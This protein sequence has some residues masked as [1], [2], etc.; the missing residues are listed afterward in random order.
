MNKIL[1]VV[2]QPPFLLFPASGSGDRAP[3]ISVHLLAFYF[4]ACLSKA[5][6][7]KLKIE[8]F[9]D[10]AAGWVS[11]EMAYDIATHAFKEVEEAHNPNRG[12]AKKLSQTGIGGC[13]PCACRIVRS[14]VTAEDWGGGLRMAAHNGRVEWLCFALNRLME[15]ASEKS[16]YETILMRDAG[17]QYRYACCK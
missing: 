4:R 11:D 16:V 14:G 1:T 13:M 15:G 3:P 17:V 8:E 5:G 2:A 7:E 12:H 10:K 9:C 6:M